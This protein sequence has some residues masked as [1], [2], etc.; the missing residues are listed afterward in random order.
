MSTSRTFMPVLGWP[1][2]RGIMPLAIALLALN[3]SA[4]AQDGA[5][6]QRAALPALV[7]QRNNAMDAAA[8]CQGDLALLKQQLAAAQ[9]E[10]E[11]LKTPPK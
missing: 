10:L 4:F 9:A 3:A 5:E 11:K 1:S 7:E 8:L 2:L 6:R